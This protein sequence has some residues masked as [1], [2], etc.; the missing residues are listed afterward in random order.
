MRWEAGLRDPWTGGAQGW[1]EDGRP[2][3]AP[4]L[5][6]RSPDI[7]SPSCSSAERSWS[8]APVSPALNPHSALTGSVAWH[9]LLNLSEL[10][11]PVCQMGVIPPAP[12]NWCGFDAKALTMCLAS[13]PVVLPEPSHLPVHLWGGPATT[14]PSLQGAPLAS[15]GNALSSSD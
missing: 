12:Q 2:L 14:A 1:T 7:V 5:S 15:S 13:L 3:Q 6:S 11:F 4:T 8:S 9:Q 10:Y